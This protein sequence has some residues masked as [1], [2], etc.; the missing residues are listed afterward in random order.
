MVDV[1]NFY[2]IF[3]YTLV[4]SIVL[5]VISII[6]SICQFVCVLFVLSL[7]S[8]ATFRSIS[9]LFYFSG[10]KLTLSTLLDVY[11][12]NSGG[13]KMGAGIEFEL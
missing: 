5:Y 4:F 11:N 7:G 13:H 1:E 6:Y 8:T 10:V 3:I 12:L 9:L 2:F